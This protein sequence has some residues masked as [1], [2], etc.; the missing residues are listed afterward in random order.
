MHQVHSAPRFSGDA[1]LAAARRL[2][3]A[4]G[5]MFPTS[6]DLAA[7]RR[8][9]GGRELAIG[10]VLLIIG[11][12]ITA[13]TYNAVKD[14]GGHYIMAYGPIAVGVINIIRGLYHLSS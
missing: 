12:V 1:D 13:G 4:A 8:K 14:S 9:Q 7:E 6:Q 10:A 11:I 5:T 2:L 3:V